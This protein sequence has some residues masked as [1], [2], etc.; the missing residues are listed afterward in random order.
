[1]RR[2]NTIAVLIA[3][4][5]ASSGCGGSE[6]T[7]SPPCEQACQDGVALR[8]LR[9]TMK[10]AYNSTVQGKP[11]GPQDGVSTLFL[12]GSARVFGTA[13]A[14]P[15]QGTTNVDLTY[16][17]S[18]VHYLFK[19]DEPEENY[20]VVIDGTLTQEGTIAI[21][22]SST[23]ALSMS[24]ENVRL[25]GQVYDPPLDYEACQEMSSCESGCTIAVTQSGNDVAGHFCGRK[26]AFS[27]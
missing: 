19:D 17:F 9:E 5:A 1:M 23:T 20:D 27:F 22:P 12:S 4:A 2:T 26:A 14:D 10:F 7:P 15:L 21:Q 25:A 24:G 6:P 11:V 3:T 13:T 16:V 8:A 18:N